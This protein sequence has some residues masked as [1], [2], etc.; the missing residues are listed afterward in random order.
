MMMFLW[1]LSSL[2][3]SDILIGRNVLCFKNDV[4]LIRGPRA[5]PLRVAAARRALRPVLDCYRGN[6]VGAVGRVCRRSFSTVAEAYLAEM[7]R[8]ALALRHSTLSRGRQVVSVAYQAAQKS[9]LCV[10]SRS[11]KSEQDKEKRLITLC[12]SQ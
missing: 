2:S 7:P 8:R 5:H 3:L 12:K 11:F 10:T 6:A 9:I 4:V 1:V